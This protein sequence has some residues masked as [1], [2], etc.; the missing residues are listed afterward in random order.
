MGERAAEAAKK[1]AKAA[2]KAAKKEVMTAKRAVTKQKKAAKK[3][4][5]RR[6]VLDGEGG[7]R[8]HLRWRTPLSRQST[9]STQGTPCAS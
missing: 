8:T 2:T 3:V 5:R 6:R 7:G 4:R 9:G 1:S